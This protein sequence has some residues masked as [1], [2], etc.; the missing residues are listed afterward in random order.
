MH[1]Y[2]N[3]QNSRFETQIAN[4]ILQNVV[5]DVGNE[6]LTRR[7]WVDHGNY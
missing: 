4:G 6:S 2:L 7:R 1:V 5:V 3:R